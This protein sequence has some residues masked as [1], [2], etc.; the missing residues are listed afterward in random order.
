MFA[1]KVLAWCVQGPGCACQYCKRKNEKQGKRG[2]T[3]HTYKHACTHTL[4]THR[5]HTHKHTYTI[6]THHIYIHHIH[7]N[8]HYGH[9]NTYI[10]YIHIKT[11]LLSQIT[12]TNT[13]SSSWL[14]WKVIFI[15]MHMLNSLRQV[16]GHPA[17][18]EVYDED[19]SSA[20]VFW[21]L[22]SL[23]GVAE[24]GRV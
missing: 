21:I 9:I 16:P 3:I 10:P 6:N 11:I 22:L 18:A 1:G 20:S 23:L 14:S 7:T 4:Q 24:A 5:E 15:F 8:T 13:V 17:R 12:L 2:V 19:N